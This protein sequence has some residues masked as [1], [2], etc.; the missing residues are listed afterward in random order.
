VGFQPA[1]LGNFDEIREGKVIDTWLM[2]N[3][4]VG[5]SMDI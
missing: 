2:D 4:L 3:I 5:R 1:K